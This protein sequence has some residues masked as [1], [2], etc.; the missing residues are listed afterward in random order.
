MWNALSAPWQVCLEEAWAAYSANSVPIGAV[1]VD[2]TGIVQ[3]RGRNQIVA[4]G[5]GEG[6]VHNH[7]LAHAELNAL[8]SYDSAQVDSSTALF[9]LLEPCPLCQLQRACV[10][11]MG[12]VFLVAALHNPGRMGATFYA[13][14]QLLIGGAGI[15]FATRHVWLQSLPKDQVPLCGM[16]LGYMLETL[17]FADVLKRVFEGSGECAVKSW[18]F[19]H[20]SIAGWTLVF[21]VAMIVGAIAMIRRD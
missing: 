10:I 21:F 13:L 5:N 20:L 18:E 8:L 3:A 2:G 15:G 14:L 4:T 17:P 12:I 1:V 16:G 6:L 19:L 7:E 9:T 11:G